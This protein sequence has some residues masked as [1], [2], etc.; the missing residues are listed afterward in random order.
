MLLRGDGVSVGIGADVVRPGASVLKLFIAIA[1][2]DAAASGALDPEASTAICELPASENPSVLTA[3]SNDHRFT[4]AELA[5]LM[6]ATSDNR[7]AEHLAFSVGFDRV[8][9]T[10][11]ALGCTSS[12]LRI[13]FSDQALDASG[14]ANVTTVTDCARALDAIWTRPD[15]TALRAA[16][17]SS[18]FNSRILSMLPDEVLVSHK[19]GS[20][21]G[22]VNDVGVLHSSTGSFVACFLTD[23]Q[24]DPIRTAADIGRCSLDALIA[25]DQR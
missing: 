24:P 4:T 6:L 7:I 16:L 10:A 9:R 13:G 3:L 2:H 15:L 25:W 12:E 8:N 22:V 17:T 19:T 21:T 14:R 20:L 18:L 23:A 11:H 1:V 5:G